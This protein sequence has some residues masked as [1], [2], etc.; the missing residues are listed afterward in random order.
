VRSYGVKA[1]AFIGAAVSTSD[2]LSDG[3]IIQ[4][5]FRTGR[6]S[7]G[8]ALMGMIGASMAMQLVVTF[9]QTRGIKKDRWMKTAKEV[10]A[11]V[12][13]TKPG[14]DAWRVA[15]GTEQ[16]T[17]AVFSPLVEMVYG[18]AAETVAESIPGLVRT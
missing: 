5:F 4:G 11:I 15:S 8:Y 1:R 10:A 3:V 16:A 9:V 13:C 2:M 17:G 6:N 14:L 18:K 7:Y 12:S